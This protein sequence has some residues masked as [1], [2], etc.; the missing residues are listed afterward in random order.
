MFKKNRLNKLNKLS[1]SLGLG[2]MLALVAGLNSATFAQ[3]G[4]DNEG[5]QSNEKSTSFGGTSGDI[6]INP[7]DL[8]HRIQQGNRRSTEEFNE[9][10][11][12]QLDNSATDFKRLQQQRILEQQSQPA[13][14][15]VESLEK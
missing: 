2:M 7:L 9:E 4:A 10:S 5:Y 13:A 11:Q 8:I 12:G 15:S 1:I 14:T 3:S 6:D